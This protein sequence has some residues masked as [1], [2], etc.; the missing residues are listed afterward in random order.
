MLQI[1]IQQPA[2]SPEANQCYVESGTANVLCF[3]R[4]DV[5][6]GVSIL[7]AANFA[8]STESVTIPA[9]YH[10]A[11]DLLGADFENQGNAIKLRPAQTV[12]LKQGGN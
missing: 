7:V 8:D 5:S 1:R 10:G 3:E 9:S 4:T 11:V 2:F 12:W 6:T